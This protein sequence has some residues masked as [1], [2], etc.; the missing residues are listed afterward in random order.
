MYENQ[1]RLYAQIKAGAYNVSSGQYLKESCVVRIE[2][3]YILGVFVRT[4]PFGMKTD[5]K[6]R[7][8]VGILRLLLDKIQSYVIKSPP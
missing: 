4:H 2:R 1:H 3:A 6:G 7:V 8:R 5:E